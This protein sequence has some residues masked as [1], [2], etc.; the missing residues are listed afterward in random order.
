MKV[1]KNEPTVEYTEKEITLAELDVMQGIILKA[2]SNLS[3]FERSWDISSEVSD[4]IIGMLKHYAEKVTELR[5][6]FAPKDDQKGFNEEIKKLRS[7]KVTI[8]L[9]KITKDE[10]KAA[11]FKDAFEIS[12]IRELGIV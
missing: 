1:E 12:A 6:K 9:A 5:K 4:K 2:Y 7:E 10:I 11:E 3:T 8:K